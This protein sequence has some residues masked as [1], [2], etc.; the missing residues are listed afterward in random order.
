MQEKAITSRRS[1]KDQLETVTTVAVL[2]AAVLVAAYF[3]TLFVRDAPVRTQPGSEAGP[4]LGMRL[5]PPDEHAFS[6]SKKTFLLALST[7]CSHCTADVPFYRQLLSIAEMADCSYEILAVFPNEEHE[8]DE[9][10]ATHDFWPRAVADVP[11]ATVG[12][13]GTPT[14]VLV[15]SQGVVEAVWVGELSPESEQEIFALVGPQSVCR[16]SEG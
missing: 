1:I 2:V 7:T 4:P 5:T 12:V 13:S 9:F 15:D 6:P 14:V 16:G 10:R 3:V 11:L 8:V